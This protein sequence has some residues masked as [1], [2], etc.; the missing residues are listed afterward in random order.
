MLSRGGFSDTSI[1]EGV[2]Q[3][4]HRNTFSHIYARNDEN[5]KSW[6]DKG[7]FFLSSQRENHNNHSGKQINV[8]L[9]GQD[10]T[11]ITSQVTS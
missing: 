4:H 10:I 7:G 5:G 11:R 9:T 2:L 6:L 3:K 1:C 8:I